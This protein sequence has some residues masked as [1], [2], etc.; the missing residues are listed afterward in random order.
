MPHTHT[1]LLG[2]KLPTGA[3]LKSQVVF[4]SPQTTFWTLEFKKPGGGGT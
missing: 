2:L 4:G 3:G 1:H